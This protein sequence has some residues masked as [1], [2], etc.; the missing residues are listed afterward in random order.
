MDE[1]TKLSSSSPRQR[2][3]SRITIVS[4]NCRDYDHKEKLSLYERKMTKEY[5][6]NEKKLKQAQKWKT[7]VEKNLMLKDIFNTTQSTTN[8]NSTQSFLS[9]SVDEWL[10]MSNKRRNTIASNHGINKIKIQIFIFPILVNNRLIF[11]L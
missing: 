6:E 11:I 5:L 2:L 9:P 3:T 4:A 7:K 8:T 10:N 1:F